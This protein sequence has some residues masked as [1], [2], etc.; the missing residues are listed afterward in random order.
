MPI[1]RTRWQRSKK[2]SASNKYGGIVGA[3]Q[4][5]EEEEARASICTVKASYYHRSVEVEELRANA[6]TREDH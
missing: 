2:G 4:T 6:A 3:E 1:S 5:G